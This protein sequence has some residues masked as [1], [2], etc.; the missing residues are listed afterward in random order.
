MSKES[1]R[2]RGMYN[3]YYVNR[4]DG[5]DSFGFK[6]HGCKLFV[7]DLNHDEYARVAALAYAAACERDYPLLARDLRLHAER[8]AAPAWSRYEYT[9]GRS[10]KF[11]EVRLSG[12]RVYVKFGRIGT[13]GTTEVKDFSF[14]NQALDYVHK[15]VEE[16]TREGYSRVY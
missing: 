1:D 12:T 14:S 6:H 13:D 11:W 8:K 2:N 7:L 16:K 4:V 10:Y 3:R 15:K 9:Y 5:Q